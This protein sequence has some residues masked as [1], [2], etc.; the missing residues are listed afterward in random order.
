MKKNILVSAVVLLACCIHAAAQNPQLPSGTAVKPSLPVP[1]NPKP[2]QPADLLITSMSLTHAAFD[3]NLK[4]WVIKVNI[5]VKNAGGLLAAPTDIKP[6]VKQTGN[7]SWKHTGTLGILIGLRPGESVT[8]E[9]VFVDKLRVLPQRGGFDF[10]VQADTG[11]KVTE[12]SENNN[13]SSVITIPA[14]Q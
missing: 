4:G 2:V 12:S 14:A 1:V 6:F 10:K 7:S 3:V 9:Y 8:K 5:T 13:F 11:N